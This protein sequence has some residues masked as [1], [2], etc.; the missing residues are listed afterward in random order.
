MEKSIPYRRI[1]GAILVLCIMLTMMPTALAR[2]TS[3][4]F[5]E[6]FE[7]VHTVTFDAN[8][9]FRPPGRQAVVDGDL[10]VRPSRNPVRD[11]F[12][13]SH[14][15][16]TQGYTWNFRRDTVYRNMTLFA[17]WTPN[18]RVGG[19]IW[20]TAPRVHDLPPSSSFGPNPWNFGSLAPVPFSGVDGSAGGRWNAHDVMLSAINN[21]RAAGLT[22]TTVNVRDVGDVPV[23]AF[24]AAA[25]AAADAGITLNIQ[26]YSVNANNMVDVRITLNPAESTKGINLSGSTLHHRAVSTRE[27]F[28]MH[29]TNNLMVIALSQPDDFGQTVRIAARLIP[30]LGIRDLHFYSYD[31]HTNMFRQIYYADYHVDSNGFVHFNTVLAGDIVISDGALSFRW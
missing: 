26:A 20:F 15:E 12:A 22:G 1:V 10:L 16:T 13:F 4:G 11:G 17:A 29:Y 9:G 31:M 25:E 5:N 21:A 27:L 2:T 8:G 23:S 30:G 24:R 6:N 7:R 28:E 18:P 14:W 19:P 3:S